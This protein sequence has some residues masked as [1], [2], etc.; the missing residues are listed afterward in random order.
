MAMVMLI[1]HGGWDLTDPPYAQV[2]RDT[3]II[4]YA[5]SGKTW[6]GANMN[7]SL[8]LSEAFQNAEP[9]QQG[10]AYQTMPNYTLSPLDTET[11]TFLESLDPGGYISIYVDADTKLCTDT[12]GD[13][14]ESG[15]HRCTGLFADPRVA[16]NDVYWMACTVIDGLFEVPSDETPVDDTER[17]NRP[18]FTLGYTPPGT[19]DQ[20]STEML[21]Q[22]YDAFDGAS[23]DDRTQAWGEF[24]DDWKRT[25]LQDQRFATMFPDG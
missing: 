4:F 17:L 15:I 8:T 9:N 14:C 3:T 22:I 5:E 10:T 11:R 20:L 24:D 6:I 18:Q 16:G 7:Q 2:P 25:L 19:P 13:Q 12:A 21:Q 1:G 23:E